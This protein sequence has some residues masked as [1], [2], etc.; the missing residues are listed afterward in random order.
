[1]CARLLFVDDETL[2]LAALLRRLDCDYEIDT[3][4]SGLAALSKLAERPYAVI[5]SDMN[6]PGMSGGTLL[7]KV[8][9]DYPST[10]RFILTGHADKDELD[11]V[12]AEA[13]II[14]VLFK[15]CQLSEI[16]LAIEDGLKAHL[17]G[18]THRH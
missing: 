2:I 16:A 14:R 6:M 17:N 4:D 15:P 11:R 9:A 18:C 5:I 12:V 7:K 3:A 10:A 8:K 1:M 13:E